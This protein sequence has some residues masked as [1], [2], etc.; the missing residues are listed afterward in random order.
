MQTYLMLLLENFINFYENFSE[1]KI[2]FQ[3]CIVRGADQPCDSKC[4]VAAA[5]SGGT[6]IGW[7]WLNSLSMSINSNRDENCTIRTVN[8]YSTHQHKPPQLLQQLQMILQYYL[9]N[10]QVW[11]LRT[12]QKYFI[13]HLWTTY[14][15][16]INNQFSGDCSTG[17]FLTANVCKH[18]WRPYL[19]CQ[20]WWR[21]ETCNNVIVLRLAWPWRLIH[22]IQNIIVN[23]NFKIMLSIGH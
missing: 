10:L 13:Q 14:L 11:E 23:L 22:F 9:T 5:G 2:G 17:Y 18:R 3:I 12:M 19:S 1:L 20:L 21:L 6:A 8:D 7:V 4:G 16:I 15:Y